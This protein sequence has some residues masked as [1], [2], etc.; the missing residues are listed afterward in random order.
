MLVAKDLDV[1]SQNGLQF[2]LI[3]VSSAV[4]NEG[5]SLS[6]EQSQALKVSSFSN[7]TLE[8]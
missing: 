3:K 2:S 4:N 1:A 7:Q 8:A 5:L 6:S